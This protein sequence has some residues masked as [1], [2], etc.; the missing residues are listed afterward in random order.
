V[1]RPDEVGLPL[2]VELVAAVHAAAAGGTPGR[3][4]VIA[5]DGPAGSGKTSLAALLANRLGDGEHDVPVVHMDDLF[6]GWDGL[7]D[8][9]PRLLEW[10]LGPLAGEGVARWRRYDWVAGGYAE[11]HE[12]PR[13]PVVVVEGVASGSRACAP[14]LALLVWVEASLDVRLARGLARDS[15]AF[16]PYWDRWAAQEQVHFTAERTRER[17]DLRL[18]TDD[19][20]PRLLS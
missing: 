10:V 15:D 17:A 2:P 12:V 6:P 3:P 18:A 11:W 19:G 20:S 1:S 14:H 13:S 5:V 7:A 16:A 4:A 9:V 8:A